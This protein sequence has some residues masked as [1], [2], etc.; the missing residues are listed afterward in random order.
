VHPK[1]TI[2]YILEV[3]K[4]SE[5]KR[6]SA[7]NEIIS[8]ITSKVNSQKGTPQGSRVASKVVSHRTNTGEVKTTLSGDKRQLYLKEKKAKTLKNAEGREIET[9]T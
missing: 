7:E 3:F 5:E 6:D 4:C 2:F 1:G 8:K 9:V